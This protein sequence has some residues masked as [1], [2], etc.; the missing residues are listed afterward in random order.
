MVSFCSLPTQLICLWSLVTAPL[1]TCTSSPGQ[2]WAPPVPHTSLKWVI[3]VISFTSIYRILNNLSIQIGRHCPTKCK[4]L[5]KSKFSKGNKSVKGLQET[6]TNNNNLVDIRAN[7]HDP[8]HSL[9][10]SHWVYFISW[11][12]L[13]LWFLWHGK[14]FPKTLT[15]PITSNYIIPA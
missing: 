2:K 7:G 13:F 15:T 9:C 11:M 6:T 5:L 1:P 3:P 14:V 8:V 12:C 10:S 4:G